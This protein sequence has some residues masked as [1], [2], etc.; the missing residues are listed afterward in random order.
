MLKRRNARCREDKRTF[1]GK[2][3]K[4][5]IGSMNI[6]IRELFSDTNRNYMLGGAVS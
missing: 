4:E 6:V 5:K 2:R 3:R 1:V